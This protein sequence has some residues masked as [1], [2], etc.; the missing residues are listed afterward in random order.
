MPLINPQAFV[1]A[2]E[3]ALVRQDLHGLLTL[4]KSRWNAGE[5]VALLKCDDADARKVAALSLSLVGGACCVDPLVQQLRDADPVVNEMAEHALWSIWFRGGTADANHQLARGAQALSRRDYEHA[6]QHFD[7]AVELCPQFA[8]AYN[9][10]AI[11]FYLL[12]RFDESV[13]DADRTVVLM[14]THFGAWCGLGHV[15]A[16]LGRTNWAIECYGR[17]IAINPHLECIRESIRALK[18]RRGR[19]SKKR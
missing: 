12:E 15:H 5:I 7:R 6:L 8:E 9:Q 16:Q 2:V 18:A 13:A 3:P 10:R 19:T 1:A 11:A 4:L 14:P 17:A